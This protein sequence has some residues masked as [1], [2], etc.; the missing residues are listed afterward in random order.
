MKMSKYIEAQ[1]LICVPAKT[2]FEFQ[3]RRML[4]LQETQRRLSKRR[5]SNYGTT[6]TLLAHLMR[7][8]CHAPT[9]TL[10]HLKRA[11]TDLNYSQVCKRFGMFFLHGLQLER[12]F[13]DGIHPSD[14]EECEKYYNKDKKRYWKR[15]GKHIKRPLLNPTV[16]LALY[17]LGPKPTWEEWKAGISQNP[18]QLV[19][20]FF[21]DETWG[22]NL[23]EQAAGSFTRFTREYLTTLRDDAL[24]GGAPRIDNLKD[25]MQVWT[26]ETM[27]ETVVSS[28][29]QPSN[30]SLSGAFQGARHISFRD[31]MSHFFPNSSQDLSESAYAPFAQ[32]GYL[33]RYHRLQLTSQDEGAALEASL[34][35][36]FERLQILPVVNPGKLLWKTSKEDGILFW[37]N[38]RYFKLQEIGPKRRFVQRERGPKVKAPMKDIIRSLKRLN[39]DTIPDIAILARENRERAQNENAKRQ[40][41]KNVA[42]RS[43][44]KNRARKPPPPRA[45]GTT[46]RKAA[47][48]SDDSDG[49]EAINR[50]LAAGGEDDDDE[51]VGATQ[52]RDESERIDAP[53]WTVLRVRSE[54]DSGNDASGYESALGDN[55]YN[56][57]GENTD[58]DSEESE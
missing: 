40:N 6:T 45:R 29:F 5:P 7:S 20:T 42:R 4:D 47:A 33:K 56:L 12:G 21:Y 8:V 13:V 44:K 23:E 27:S 49:E 9:A 17:P 54:S 36:I 2:F 1:P 43:A 11:L 53:R 46:Q 22:A 48:G 52:R 10:P 18:A 31:Q 39:S 28:G 15:V 24:R 25:S 16:D 34:G 35:D 14:D 38:S 30:H 37:A 26:V 55:A 32:Y 51:G 58:C 57:E 3:A 19:N 41:S 50:P